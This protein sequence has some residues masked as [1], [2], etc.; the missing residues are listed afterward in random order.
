MLNALV[1]VR[2]GPPVGS[3]VLQEARR[4]SVQIL[5]RE[6]PVFDGLAKRVRNGAL[7][8]CRLHQMA[9]A[10]IK[11]QFAAW[12]WLVPIQQLPK[13][14]H[15]E[16]EVACELLRGVGLTHC[17]SSICSAAGWQM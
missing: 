1:T 7:I 8:E 6:V 9:S 15:E 16:P 4:W 11:S 2:E 12:G 14:L 5:K 17:S 3:G 13:A 10:Y